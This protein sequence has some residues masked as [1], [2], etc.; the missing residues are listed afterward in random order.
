MNSYFTWESYFSG[1]FSGSVLVAQ[2]DNVLLNK[3]YGI[4]NL[5]HNV[6]NHSK[7]K[8]RIGSITKQFTIMLHII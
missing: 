7:T 2:K 3:S 4:S 8:F 6:P 1:Y 5:E